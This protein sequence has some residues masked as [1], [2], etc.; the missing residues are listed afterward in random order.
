[1]YPHTSQTYFFITETIIQKNCHSLM[2]LYIPE[3]GKEHTPVLIGCRLKPSRQYTLHCKVSN[4]FR[5]EIFLLILFTQFVHQT[6]VVFSCIWKSQRQ[7]ARQWREKRRSVNF[8]ILEQQLCFL[9][10]GR[11]Y[12]APPILEPVSVANADTEPLQKQTDMQF[13]SVMFRYNYKTDLS[14][15]QDAT[16]LC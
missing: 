9:L 10:Y 7:S 5:N 6:S 2:S 15:M 8:I 4:K 3:S 14:I 12:I 16:I 1:M 13:P 11:R